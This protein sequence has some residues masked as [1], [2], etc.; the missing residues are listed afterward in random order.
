MNGR[1]SRVSREEILIATGGAVALAVVALV[2]LALLRTARL[3]RELDALRSELDRR[4]TTPA[5][6]QPAPAE[7]TY[8]I[9]GFPEDGVPQGTTPQHEVGSGRVAEPI[10]GRLFADIVARETVVRAGGLVHG[11]RRALDAE[12]RNRIRFEMRRELRRSRKQ[13]RADLKAAMR[14]FR[15]RER[16][17]QPAGDEEDAA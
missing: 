5:A 2:V 6:E 12:T 3:R 17:A 8:V 13:R 1:V 4:T 9:T 16:A 7:A 11:L 10:D 15:D 14:D